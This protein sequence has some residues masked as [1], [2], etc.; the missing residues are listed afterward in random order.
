MPCASRPTGGSPGRLIWSSSTRSTSGHPGT[1]HPLKQFAARGV[2][3][4]W[5]VVELRRNALARTAAD[6]LDA[7]AARMPFPVRASS[8]EDG[9][10][11]MAE[12]ETACVERGIR[13]YVR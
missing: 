5:D 11:F 9:S 7:L 10:E 2:I 3:S 8:V 12:F 6:V 1:T 13:L 4:R